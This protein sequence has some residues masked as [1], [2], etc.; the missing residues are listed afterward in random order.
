MAIGVRVKLVYPADLITVPVIARLAKDFDV[1]ANIR[2]AAVDGDTGWIVC[3]LEGSNDD[4]KRSLEWLTQLGV[5]V[6]RL[7]DVVES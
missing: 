6:E 5:S 1:L 2:R 3:E 7:S 4:I